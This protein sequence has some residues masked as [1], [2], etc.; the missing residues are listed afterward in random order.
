VRRWWRVVPVLLLLLGGV[1]LPA[2]ASPASS[3]ITMLNFVFT[4]DP[5]APRLGDKATWWNEPNNRSRHTTTDMSALALWDSGELGE[6]QTFTYTFTAAGTYSYECTIHVDFGMVGT[7]GV[8]DLTS[9]PSGPVGT[10]FTITVASIDAPVGMGYDIQKRNPG[11]RFRNWIT[12]TTS[13]TVQF[14][15]TGQVPGMYGFHSRLRRLSDNA[16]IAY[17]PLGSIKVTS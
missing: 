14:D 1:L 2:D 16:S 3:K 9:P 7:V 5:A 4:P 6:W 13:P 15:S 10:V 11:G 8:R 17:S 12:G